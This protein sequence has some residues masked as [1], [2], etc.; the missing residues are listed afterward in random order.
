[1]TFFWNLID[2]ERKLSPS[3]A[4]M[5]QVTVENTVGALQIGITV[6]T[7]LFGIVTMQCYQYLKSY[8]DDAAIFKVLVR[9]SLSWCDSG[10]SFPRLLPGGCFWLASFLCYSRDDYALTQNS[11]LWSLH[12]RSASPIRCTLWR[13]WGPNQL[14]S[15]VSELQWLL[16]GWLRPL[17][18]CV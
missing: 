3:S 6:S 8:P 13:S 12:N 14:V 5:V 4:G 9:D 18:R 17:C 15:S 2:I 10:G 1:M 16:E 7:L 11:G